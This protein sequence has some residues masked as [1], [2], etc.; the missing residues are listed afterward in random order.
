MERGVLSRRSFVRGSAAAIATG[1]TGAVL[2]GCGGESAGTDGRVPVTF[3]AILDPEGLTFAPELLGIAG[4]YFADQG[5]DVSLQRTRGSAPAILTVIEGGAPLTRI[6]QIEGVGHLA[7]RGVP[8]RNVGTVIKKSAIRFVSSAGAPIREPQDFVG[9]L[10]GIPSEGGSS[11]KTLDLV[12]S[13]AGIDPESVERQVVGTNAAVFDLIER[14][15]IQSFAVSIDVANILSRQRDNVVVLSPGDFIASGAQFY[16]VSEEGLSEHRDTI[17]RYLAATK[18]AIEFMIDDDGFDRTI[19]ILRQEYSFATLDNTE[20]AK[21]SLATYVDIWT[22][23]GRENLMR[24]DA[25][26][27]RTGYEELVMAGL[28]EAGHDPDAWY[29]NEL[30]SSV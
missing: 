7:N 16:M 25:D 24:T 17:R 12:L 9:K 3:L 1:T 27:W 4:G 19:E 28:V 26:S 21:A 20:I 30:V 10:I 5:L 6:E 23:E 18:A 29:T 8:I 13:S 14:G 11:D 2:I 22:A 15:Q